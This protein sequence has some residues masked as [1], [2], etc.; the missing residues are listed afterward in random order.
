MK[1]KYEAIVSV[2]TA[3]LFLVGASG[4]VR[5]DNVLVADGPGQNRTSVAQIYSTSTAQPAILAIRGGTILSISD[6]VTILP[7]G[8][9]T[10]LEAEDN[11]SRITAEN[12]RILALDL[13]QTGISAVSAVNGGLVKL[14][15][16]NIGIAGGRSIGLLAD[17]GTVNVSDAVAISMTGPNSYGVE[18]SGGGLV[19]INPGTTITTSG[20]GGIW[21]FRAGWRNRDSKRNLDHNLRFLVAG[22]IQC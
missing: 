2:L 10:G 15:G 1:L 22:R 13:G 21:H 9:I 16:G 14:E 5:A 20:I 4:P 12:P 8:G 3:L 17:N 18:A 7:P 11:G 6:L 19:E